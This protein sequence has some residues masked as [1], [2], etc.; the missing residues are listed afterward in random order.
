[1]LKLGSQSTIVSSSNNTRKGPSVSEELEERERENLW[2]FS[3]DVKDEQEMIEYDNSS[4]S[5][6]SD[7]H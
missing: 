3:D 6:P 5:R 1:M 7:C 4:V 2:Q